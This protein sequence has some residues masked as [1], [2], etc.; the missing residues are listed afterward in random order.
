MSDHGEHDGARQPHAGG[1]HVET[2]EQ[3]EAVDEDH[4]GG[5]DKGH[6][7]PA[8]HVDRLGSGNTGAHS[9]LGQE[10]Q[11]RG[12]AKPVVA[13]PDSQGGG[14]RDQHDRPT[15]G[16]ADHHTGEDRH[17]TQIRH[18]SFV[19]L[20]CPGTVHHAGPASDHDAHR[21]GQRRDGQSGHG[22]EHDLRAHGFASL[23][24]A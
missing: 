21:Y 14:H 8:R 1:Q 22:D 9:Q 17:P 23:P 4:G 6:T 11:L 18:G 13:D 10:P 7:E 16:P 2:V 24:T 20:E 15:S 12:D 5:H 3:V 19:G